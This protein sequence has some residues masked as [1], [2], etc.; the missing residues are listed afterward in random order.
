MYVCINMYEAGKT[1]HQSSRDH[2]P[3][4]RRNIMDVKISE[5]ISV[6]PARAPFPHDH[7]IPLSHLDNDGN[8]QVPIRCL[9]VYTTTAHSP[10]PA[11]PFRVITAALSEALVHY[12][13]FGGS[14]RR[15]PGNH[16]LELLCARGKGVPLIRATA[17]FT[18]ESVNYLDDPAAPF[19][20]RLV[21]D[22]NPEEELV[23]PFVL[24]VTVFACGGY[25]L[26][27][28]L[29]QS[30]C[31]GLAAAQFFDG[32]GELARGATRPSLDPV[33]ERPAQVGP[34]DPPHVEAPWHEFLS[35]DK[36]SSPYGHISGSARRECFSVEDECLDRFRTT[37]FE[38]SGLKFTAFEALGAYIWRAKVKASGIVDGEKVKFVYSVNIRKL[39][40]SPLPDGY[41]GN[42]CVPVYVQL[43][44]KELVEQ[45]IWET[46]HLIKKS[47]FNATEEYVRSFIDF[48]ELNYQEGI[49]AG[50]RV[51]S[52]I[53]WR[54]YDHSTQDFGSGGP[55]SILPISRKFLGSVEPCF[56]LP[57]SSLD[58]GKKNGFRVLVFLPNTTLPSFKEE[59][60]KFS[61]EEFG[62]VDKK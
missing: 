12:P 60:E 8:L 37:L 32:M 59:M 2:K 55:V 52:F 48:Q 36:S 40:K 16:R 3:T 41:C 47:K 19:I 30:L 31:D 56:F 46:A 21:P 51:S 35:L 62:L 26:G 13:L 33:L 7:L 1:S 45:P 53:N 18:L 27:F 4:Q 49:T 14:L 22:P 5:T 39:L 17:N 20:E 42:A 25:C 57:H 6:L 44:A 10:N 50:K 38:Q 28:S 34:R 15:H 61:N 24:Q 9:R 29:I 54:H 23:N 43:S 11:D 58:L